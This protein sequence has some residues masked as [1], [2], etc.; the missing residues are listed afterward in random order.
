MRRRF[1]RRILA[2]IDDRFYKP[3][4]VPMQNLEVV[5]VSKE[6]LE[7]IRLRYIKGQDQ[8]KAATSMGVSQSQYQRD[9]TDTLYKITEAMVNGKAIRISGRTKS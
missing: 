8:T 6:D 5:E 9:L 3:A 1:R 7:T 2:S 4:G